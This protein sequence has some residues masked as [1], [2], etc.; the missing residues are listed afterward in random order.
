M[1]IP[2]NPDVQ[3][4]VILGSLES[5]KTDMDTSHADPLSKQTLTSRLTKYLFCDSKLSSVKLK[6][7][8]F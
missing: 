2:P 8:Q 5:F 3:S 7:I 6:Y 4:H 1:S